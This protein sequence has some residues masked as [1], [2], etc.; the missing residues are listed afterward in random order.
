MREIVMSGAKY[1]LIFEDDV[2]LGDKQEF[3]TELAKVEEFLNDSTDEWDI[4]RLGGL[5]FSFNKPSQ[6]DSGIWEARSNANHAYFISAAYVGRLMAQ[7]NFDPYTFR[8]GI[9][10]Y[11]RTQDCRDFITTRYQCHQRPQPALETDQRSDNKW[12]A[13][14]FGFQAVVEH[15]WVFKPMQRLTNWIAWKVRWLPSKIQPLLNPFPLAVLCMARYNDM[16]TEKL[17]NIPVY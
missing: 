13:R 12:Y 5:V 3:Q 7:H 14:D 6:F 2:D 4:V 8:G 10:D 9:D 1:G 17:K 16:T 11:F 15:P